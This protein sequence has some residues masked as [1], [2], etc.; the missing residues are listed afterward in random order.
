MDQVQ[1]ISLY[2]YLIQY[3]EHISNVTIYKEDLMKF[4]LNTMLVAD[5]KRLSYA[6]DVKIKDLRTGLINI[7]LQLPEFTLFI[8]DDGPTDEPDYDPNYKY[9]GSV[10][11]ILKENENYII[12]TFNSYN[13]QYDEFIANGVILDYDYIGQDWNQPKDKFFITYY[14]NTFDLYSVAVPL[15]HYTDIRDKII[16][17]L[18][19][20]NDTFN[21]IG[22]N[23]TVSI[24]L[25][26]YPLNGAAP[27]RTRLT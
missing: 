17:R 26:F 1:L 23:A 4:I 9:N 11:I 7:L 24:T 12:N 27:I 2:N 21:K 14:A 22:Y 25:L 6:L 3:V 20:Y 16:T 5:K 13:Q 18:A 10:F 19:S 15:E 8:I